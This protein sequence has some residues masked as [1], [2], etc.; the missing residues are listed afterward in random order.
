MDPLERWAEFYTG[1]VERVPC[2]VPQ[3]EEF[4]IPRV[5]IVVLPRLL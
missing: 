1:L 4:E 3:K 2:R 5:S